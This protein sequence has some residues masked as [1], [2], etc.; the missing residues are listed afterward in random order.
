MRRLVPMLIVCLAAAP[1]FAEPP[2]TDAQCEALTRLAMPHASITQATVERSGTFHE[3]HG[4]GGK[5]HDHTDLP[6]FCRVL[7]TS[8]P[9]PDSKIGFE[10]WL[11]LGGWSGR[12]QAIGNGAYDD[13]IYYAQMVQRVQAGDVVVG[14]DTGHKG[15]DLK[16][17]VGHPEAIVDWGGGRAVHESTVAAK[18]VATTLLGAG[19]RYSYFAGCSTGGH[20]ALAAAQRYPDDYD[21]IIAGDPGNDRTNLNLTFLWHFLKNHPEGDYSKPILTPDTLRLVHKEAVEAC[22]ALDGV[23]DGVINDPRQCKFD[24][25]SLVCKPGDGESA[26][27]RRSQVKAMKAMYAGPT[28]VRT[29]QPIYA[30]FLPGSEGSMAKPTDKYPGWSAYWANPRKPDEPQ[31]IDSIRL[32][33]YDKPNWNWWS[34]DW[35]KDIDTVRAKLS[36]M[37]DATDP[38]LSAF[39]RHGGKLIMF[40]GWDDPVGAASDIIGY[41]DKLATPADYARLYMVPGMV[42]CALGPGA[43]N[44]STATRDSVPP[45]SDAK[46]DMGVALREWVEK[47]EAPHEIVATHFDGPQASEGKGKIAFQRPLCPWPQVAHYEGGPTDKAESFTC[48]AP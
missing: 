10:I 7:G 12:L 24:V 8:T 35:G 18:Q 33:V 6:P 15:G 5:P 38:D 42:H 14:T 30:P 37:I 2:V 16:F 28:D 11:P 22:D 32:W 1:A 4:P 44:F 13:R 46:H 26:C 36:P 20:Q 9:V 48:A 31:R 45:V 27:L 17:G 19:P 3:E 21:G 39:R 25:A 40:M 34:F 47:G 23:K 29:H 41:Y 43:T